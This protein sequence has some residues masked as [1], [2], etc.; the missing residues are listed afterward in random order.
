MELRILTPLTRITCVLA[1]AAISAVVIHAGSKTTAPVVK[2]FPLDERVVYEIPIGMSVPTTIMFPSAP[3]ALESA[4]ITAKPETPAPVLLSHTPGHHYLSVRALKPDAQATLNVIWKNRTYIIRFTA[5]EKPYGSVTFYED[6]LAGRSPALAKR[7]T[8]D[9]LLELLDRAKSYRIVRDQYPEAVQQ[10]EH[11]A[12]PISE[13]VTRYKEFSVTVEEVFRFDP[14]DTLIFRL[15]LENTGDTEVAYQPQSLAARIGS[16]VY[17]AS[18]S[19]ASGLIPPHAGTTA[20]FAITGKPDGSRANLSV[21]NKFN[22]I[23]PRVT[24]DV[25]LI[26]PR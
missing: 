25:Q 1:F 9:V 5:S 14:E 19:D 26:E 12:P 3:S 22:I 20:Y 10:I 11:R 8:P 21:K 4:G 2:Q 7:A 6:R 13:A 15:R 16:R 23:V 17:T 24:R 18:V